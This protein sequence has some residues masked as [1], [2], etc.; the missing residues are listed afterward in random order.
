ML[1]INEIHLKS[2]QRYFMVFILGIAVFTAPQVWYFSPD[3]GYYIGTVIELLES[4]SYSFNGYPNLQYYP[5]TSW[6]FAIPILIFGLDFHLLHVFYCVFVVA[7]IW[8]SAK[9][10]NAERFGNI[11]LL[12]PVLLVLN[13][14]I[15]KETNVLLSGTPFAFCILAALLLWRKFE[16][17]RSIVFLCTVV[18]FVSLGP[19][20]RTEGVFLISAFGLAYLI[21][22]IKHLGF[23]IRA[24]LIPSLLTL[25]TFIPFAL[26]TYRNYLM[27]S[28][29]TYNMANAVFF[30]LK[31]LAL[32]G[33]G[34]GHLDVV[35]DKSAV[36]YY[37]LYYT[38]IDLAESYIG[39]IVV[40]QGNFGRFI[41]P[42]FLIGMCIATV[43]GVKR[44]VTKANA[45]ET[46]LFTSILF[47]VIYWAL[48]QNSLNPVVRIWMPLIPFLTFLIILGMD[49]FL[50]LC[51]NNLVRIGVSAVYAF[52]FVIVLA[53]GVLSFASFKS[54]NVASYN[55]NR[56]VVMTQI[57]EYIKSN[58]P[59]DVVLTTDD[60]GVFPLKTDRQSYMILNGN[61]YLAI[62][63]RMHKYNSSYL[64]SLEGFT[65]QSK[66][67][68]PLVEK[69]PSIFSLEREFNNN[70]AAPS[71]FVYE[72]DKIS[73]DEEI[74]LLSTMKQ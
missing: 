67:V 66:S 9:I 16:E 60:W 43:F 62:L 25:L 18:F 3:S 14:L 47:F 23:S 65:V 36:G 35:V 29:D 15:Q 48:K 8:L 53:N 74:K 30:G 63:Q 27:H 46:V 17:S 5:G 64:V 56:N 34:F 71:G 28:P 11:S 51:K 70:Q 50:K 33:P 26:W 44:W 4:G 59:S 13:T 20:I 69:Y 55:E 19:L 54:E 1:S 49:S 12:L 41:V 73:L 39:Q 52:V 37:N 72:I 45:M 61:N 31:G 57:A 38:L 6:F 7:V 22:S 2:I 10:F 68:A 58:T 42:L 21:H 40:Y 24:F 32:Y